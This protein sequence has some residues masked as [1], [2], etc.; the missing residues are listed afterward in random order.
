MFVQKSN[1]KFFTSIIIVF[2]PY[3]VIFMLLSHFELEE[4]EFQWAQRVQQICRPWFIWQQNYRKCLLNFMKT[5]QS[6]NHMHVAIGNCLG[7]STFEM[8]NV[9][10]LNN[11]DD[12]KLI[13]PPRSNNTPCTELTLGVGNDIG[14]ERQLLKLVPHCVFY[15]ADPILQ[16]GK[17]FTEMGKYYE[18]AVSGHNGILKSSVLFNNV[19]STKEVSNIEFVQF[20]TQTIGYRTFDYFFLDNEGPE[21]DILPM[22]HRGG[23]V[24][25]NG[26]ILCQISVE[27]HGPLNA[28]G[29]NETKYDLVIKNLIAFSPFIP[30]WQAAPANHVRMFLFNA[31]N[32]YCV[33]NFLQSFCHSE[34]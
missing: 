30:I 24:E 16:S 19:Y 10:L 21:Y 5:R 27:L 2:C 9:K 34:K 20:I 25:T 4:D 26:I 13:I 7:Q 11:L 6:W 23:A 29:M 28:Y 14:A 12:V 22:L 32:E 33:E 3:L 1:A 8:M 31:E 18:V 15:G 17:I